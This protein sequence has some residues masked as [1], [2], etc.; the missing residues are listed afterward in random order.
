VPVRRRDYPEVL[1]NVLTA[2][3]GGVAAERHPFPPLGEATPPRHLLEQPEAR[4][5]VSVFGFLSGASHRFRDTV[6]FELAGDGQTLIWRQG[7]Q[8]PDAGSLIHVNYLR[9]DDPPTLT[10]LE[11]GGVART[12][13][14][15]VGLEIARLY[16]QL[17]AVH[18]A[19]YIDTATGSELDKVVALLGIR[20]VPADRPTA[21]LRF[22]RVGGTPGAIT[23]PAGTRVIDEKVQ[24]E[25]EVV[26]TVTMAQTQNSITVSVRDVEP[27]NDPVDA[28]VLAVLAVPI[29]GIAGVVNPAPAIRAAEAETDEELRTRARTFL[30]GSERATLGALRHALARQQVEADIEEPA[31]EPGLVRVTPHLDSLTPE[32]AEQLRSALNDVRPAGVVVDLAAPLAPARVDLEIEITSRVGLQATDL[33]AAHA[34][35]RTRIETYFEDLPAREDGR[36]NRLV[37]T[38]LA[39]EGIEDVALLSATVTE[40]ADGST[41]LEDRLDLAA[42]IIAL[43][44]LPTVLGELSIADRNLPTTVNLVINFP[45]GEAAPDETAVV[46]A[47]EAALA[48]LEEAAQSDIDPMDAAALARRTLS[49]GKILFVLPAPV[50]P[51]GTLAALEGPGPAP[52]LPTTAEVA[53]YQVSAFVAQA[54]GLTRTL[55]ADGDAYQLT[56][57]E[58]LLLDAVT[59]A[60]ED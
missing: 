32:R 29:A 16:A 49:F 45:S 31:G 14:Q 37:G 56:T 46:A 21:K 23:I 41:T 22:S 47:L 48:Y 59:I 54:N 40:T 36:V 55:T 34:E 20:R 28:N 3:V 30:H 42:G 24:V 17:E 44:D 1:D 58:R 27:A 53:P 11:I 52:T 57:R 8:Q 15:S 35:V 25:Y 26:E 12:I 19:G 7:G 43:A 18:R 13:V 60:V 4:Q 6:D 10:D 33:A 50:G 5:I 9:K 39:V 51:G 38:I 2:L